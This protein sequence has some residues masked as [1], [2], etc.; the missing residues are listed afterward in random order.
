MKVLNI[1][2]LLFTLVVVA[3]ASGKSPKVMMIYLSLCNH[4]LDIFLNSVL[5][6]NLPKV[7]HF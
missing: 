3:E 2:G 7:K 1:L 5:F 4:V 6:V